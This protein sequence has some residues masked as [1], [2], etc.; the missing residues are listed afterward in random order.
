MPDNPANAQPMTLGPHDPR[1]LEE[2]H[3]PLCL[4]AVVDIGM[5]ISAH[6]SKGRVDRLLEQAKQTGDPIEAMMIE[7]LCLAHHRIAG[8]HAR[9]AT[10]KDP[11]VID[12]Y[13]SN[14]RQL[15]GEFRRLALALREYRTPAQG[16]QTTV[17]HR[18]EQLNQAEGRQSV[19]YAKAEGPEGGSRME[20]RDSE[21]TSNTAQEPCDELHEQ[22]ERRLEESQAGCGRSAEPIE[23]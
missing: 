6:A 11:K 4:D 2:L 1:I 12:M 5:S 14:A 23:A 13:S 7:Q 21:L 3:I 19:S 18:V 15:L 8:L 16:K 9:A 20:C 10:S 17:I 22:R